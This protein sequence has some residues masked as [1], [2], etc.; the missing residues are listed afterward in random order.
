MFGGYDDDVGITLADTTV[1]Q[2]SEWCGICRMCAD[3]GVH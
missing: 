2:F 3:E 1:L